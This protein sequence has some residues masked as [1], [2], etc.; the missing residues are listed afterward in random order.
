VRPEYAEN[1]RVPREE[2]IHVAQQAA[3][4]ATDQLVRAEI[5][6]RLQIIMNRH[7]WAIT[8]DE[9]REMIKEVRQMRKTG[10]Y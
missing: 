1:V 10:R 8:D 4:V 7:R 5:E 2:L 9:V 6:A 3:V